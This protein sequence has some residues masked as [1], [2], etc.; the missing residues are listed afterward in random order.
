[1]TTTP[2]DTASAWDALDGVHLPRGY[3]VEITDGKITMTPQGE[4]QWKVI[5]KAAPQI[6]QQLANHGDILSDVMIDFPS[7][8]YGYAPD[9]AIIAPGSER[10]SRGRFEWH[11]LEAVLEVV[12]KSTQDNDFSKK[13]RMY[14]ECGIPV[15]VIIDPST[16]TCT[17]YRHPTRTG[18]Y[19]DEDEV[20]F[21]QD[22]VLPLEGR[23]IV[24]TTDGFPVADGSSR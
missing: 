20:P 10:N 23:D 1:M 2:M 6:E 18:T 8:L 9:L 12:S 7:S 24:V 4:N 11:S 5:L 3:R 13:F 14:A 19:R 17:I 16:G 15:Y 22:L 21:G